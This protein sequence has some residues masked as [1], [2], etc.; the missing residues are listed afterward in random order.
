MRNKKKGKESA[1]K[2]R[3]AL[4]LRGYLNDTTKIACDRLELEYGLYF[5]AFDMDWD[6]NYTSMG[7]PHP[8]TIKNNAN[9]NIAT[10]LK[11][12]KIMEYLD[13]EPIQK[14]SEAQKK[15]NKLLN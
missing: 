5:G 13:S 2:I 7:T 4:N 14:E 8:N 15:L 11:S 6:S 12:Y 10:I 9:T 1:D 3:N